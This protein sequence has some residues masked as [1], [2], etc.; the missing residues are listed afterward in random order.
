MATQ[1]GTSIKGKA[2]TPKSKVHEIA[3]GSLRLKNNILAAPMCG[4]S[5]S[6]FRYLAKKFGA[7][8]VCTEMTSSDALVR[9][10]ERTL[11]RLAFTDEERPVSIQISGCE[12]EVVS[13]AVKILRKLEPDVLDLNLGCP[14]PKVTSR[15]AGA[16]LLKDPKRA[17]AIA[18]AAVKEAGD[19][20]VTAKFRLGWDDSS[21]TYDEVGPLFEDAGIA[22]I[23]VHARTR[24]MRFSGT[25]MWEHVA[26][27]KKMVSI[28]VI[29]NGDIR[30][31][32]D[33]LRVL[34]KTGADGVMLGRGAVSNPWLFGE[35]KAVLEGKD[36]SSP[37]RT[38]R[39]E[40][41]KELRDGLIDFLSLQQGLLMIRGFAGPLLSGMSGARH[42][43]R[44]FVLAQTILEQDQV[45]ENFIQAN[46]DVEES[47]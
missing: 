27:L 5:L 14:V 16:G 9:A 41:L 34:E 13:A 8:L 45:L 47:S 4:V 23:S 39:V 35:V 24:A 44:D 21:L 1:A 15:M 7:G 30:T 42:A 32:A 38:Q 36:F 6:P 22:M 37:S 43:R 31:G 3:V 12:P 20:P 18:N 17:V 33:A 40:F 11:K 10:Q 19:I 26:K 25:P 46:D 28:P 2:M 29:A